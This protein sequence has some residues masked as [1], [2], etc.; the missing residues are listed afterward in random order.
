MDERTES[1]TF[2]P[3]DPYGVP[4]ARDPLIGRETEVADGCAPPK[5]AC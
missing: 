4:I 1:A 2:D 5:R 3:L